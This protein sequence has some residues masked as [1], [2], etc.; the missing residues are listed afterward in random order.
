MDLHTLSLPRVLLAALAL[1]ACSS[2]QEKK[3]DPQ[4]QL[5]LYRE[6]ALYHYE[7]GDLLRAEGQALKGLAVDGEDKAL[8]LMVGWILLRRGDVESLERA[9]WVFRG[10]LDDHP[11]ENRAM[12]GLAGSLER[13]G[14]VEVALAAS[15]E[16]GERLPDRGSPAERAAGLRKLAQEGWQE[17]YEL[18]SAAFE[19]RQDD[20]DALDGLQRSSARLG[21]LEESL[22]WSAE[23]LERATRERAWYRTRLESTN[24]ADREERRLRDGEQAAVRLMADTHLF[25]NAQLVALG[26][27]SDALGELDQAIE[28]DPTDETTFSRRAQLRY[29][30]GDYTGARAD[31]EVFIANSPHATD[32]PDIRRAFELLDHAEREDPSLAW[33]ASIASA[34]R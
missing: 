9:E 31:V 6:T 24:L 13:I 20:L 32:H 10:Y 23:L 16:R 8:R 2:T 27:L 21:R 34:A 15:I 30:Q 25:A 28:L 11:G 29:L 5:D 12:L 3:L 14:A 33:V 26:R 22:E 1:G 18:Y 19:E 7:N 17:A 4:A